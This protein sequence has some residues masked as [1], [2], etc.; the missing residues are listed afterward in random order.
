MQTFEWPRIA[1]VEF[2]LALLGECHDAGLLMCAG[3]TAFT[4]RCSQRPHLDCA[5]TA[6][7]WGRGLAARRA[8]GP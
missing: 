2:H 5:G 6:R 1:T 3:A 8:C 7:S 4:C